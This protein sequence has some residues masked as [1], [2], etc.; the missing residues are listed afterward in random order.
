MGDSRAV[1][2]D[3]EVFICRDMKTQHLCVEDDTACSSNNREQTLRDKPEEEAD[4]VTR[5]PDSVV[6]CPS[7]NIIDRNKKKNCGKHE[8]ALK[9]METQ[10][11]QLSQ[12]C[13]I[14]VTNLCKQTLSSLE[15]VDLRLNILKDRM[16]K[17]EDLS[18]K[19][20]YAL[21]DKVEEEVKLKKTMI[22]E[23]NLRLREVEKRRGS[24]I[25]AILRR[26]C[27]MVEKIGFLTPPAVHRLFHTEATKV[28]L[29][30]IAN[31]RCAARVELDLKKQTLQQEAQLHQ[32]W[33]D[34]LTCWRRSKEKEII[35]QFRTFSGR[36]EKQQLIPDEQR[37]QTQRVLTEQRCDVICKIC[38]LVP[39]ACSSALVSDWFMELTSLNSQL[40]H[41]HSDF[42]THCRCCEE[43]SWDDLLRE[44]EHCKKALSALQLS[45][46]QV[47]DI[48]T[49]QL[50]PL[51][52]QRQSRDEGRLAALE[53][54][55]D[56]VAQHALKLSG[57]VFAVVKAAA[58]Q[59]EEHV[60]RSERIQEKVEQRLDDLKCSLQQRTER[61]RENLDNLIQRLRQA[62]SEDVMK[63]LLEKSEKL[64]QDIEHSCKE[65]VSEQWEVLSH[66]PA[67]LM[68]EL[69]LYSKTL[70]SFFHL[71]QAYQPGLED[72]QKLHLSSSSI[73]R[74][75]SGSPLC[76]HSSTQLD[77]STKTVVWQSNADTTHNSHNCFNKMESPLLE[78]SD[79]K[80]CATFTSTRGV[81]YTGPTF[82]CLAPNLPSSLQQETH[83]STFPVEILTDTLTRFRVLFL[84]HLEQH[85]SEV[86]SSSVA[87]VAQRKDA[88]RIE[89][90]L[91]L[92]QL[93]PKHIQT[94]ICQPRLVC[95]LCLSAELQLHQEI[96]DNFCEEMLKVFATC[97]MELQKLQSIISKRNQ[98]FMTTLSKTE[99]SIR[100]VC[101]SRRLDAVVSAFQDSL[102]RHTEE[103]QHH[104]MVF[105]QTLSMRLEET[106]SKVSG[107]LNSMRMFSEGGDFAPEELRTIQTRI[108]KE[109]KKISLTEKS[110]LTELESFESKSFQQVKELSSHLLEKLSSLKSEVE[111]A[112]RIRKILSNAQLQIQTEAAGSNL[113]QTSVSICLEK[114]KAFQKN[115]KESPKDVCS[116]LSSVV[117][118][119]QKRCLYLDFNMGM[120]GLMAR[121][122]SL[123]AVHPTLSFNHLNSP[124]VE[125]L[126]D[127]IVG[128]LK[129]MNSGLTLHDSAVEDQQ[130]GRA[131]SGQNLIQNQK[132][133]A[134]NVRPI[135][136]GSRSIRN[137]KRFQIFGSKLEEEQSIAS[138]TSVLQSV[139][140]KTNDTLLQS[141]EDFYISKSGSSVLLL[142]DSLDK[143]AE[144]MMR[145]L[146]EYQKQANRFLSKS[147]EELVK[148]LFVL[149]ELLSS[150]PAVMISKHEQ[151]HKVWLNEQLAGIMKKLEET[152]AASEK[153][154]T[155]NFRELRVSMTEGMLEMVN[156]REELRQQKL[157][158]AICCAHL[159]L[160]ESLQARG[161]EF[162]TSLTLLSETL[163]HQ[164][165]NLFS[166]TA[167]K[168]TSL[169][170]QQSEDTA[171]TKGAGAESREAIRPSSSTAAT[172][173]KTQE[174]VAEHRDA[175]LKRFEELLK[176]ES[177]GLDDDK[178]RQLNK[179]DQWNAYWRR[180]IQALKNIRE[181][182]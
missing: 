64:L 141:A 73:D 124:S 138:F 8:E 82:R 171:V 150:L 7:S 65:C 29:A 80:L 43:Q 135:S 22:S 46:E 119:V 108:E 182:F 55:C 130:R 136:K 132:L 27:H 39:P 32:Q 109:T 157:H 178:R 114:L 117:E 160:Q 170:H 96:V 37:E 61:K 31:R 179:E 88:V 47:N 95:C 99:S 71:T 30:L 4:E 21:W 5:L 59:W 25:Q 161:K 41:L 89:Q 167:A 16:G 134:V 23:L 94:H 137:N 90:E 101:S 98:E 107:L 72:L 93:N 58:L 83:L 113:Q 91:Q 68:E 162:V 131:A 175:A 18:L 145:L 28:N 146:L 44:V 3:S 70:S 62:S 52:R 102:D 122:K 127:P 154:R 126:Q 85:F 15:E 116:L 10:L 34:G 9:Q 174:V 19:E 26:F 169:T 164:T 125:H 35:D 152:L 92:Q 24:E 6:Q 103:T 20:V 142:P 97:R 111:F 133:T 153:E 40:D 17:L 81:I 159:Q 50:L 105:R 128:I 180:E 100:V 48:V 115:T 12:E 144:N 156:S 54:C 176:L 172:H 121:P 67:L 1:L 168:N 104:Q 106:R 53:M 173:T 149:K 177:L 112:E 110:I 49:S 118:E 69:L 38:S 77:E 78:L 165:D 181:N 140:W 11:S 74:L 158:S 60:F 86:L 56:A 148:Q 2:F 76:S 155:S 143:W 57:H 129:S 66:L 79:I 36:D 14:Q 63:S 120:L 51:I 45:E 151:Q 84:D 163:L 87:M 139:L 42:L 75:I 166:A 123:K 147:R 33:E 13:E